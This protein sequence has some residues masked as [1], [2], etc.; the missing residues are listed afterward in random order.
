[1]GDV[2]PR[3]G[4]GHRAA[5]ALATA[6]RTQPTFLDGVVT[7]VVGNLF[8]NFLFV[9]AALHWY[10]S[11]VATPWTR[12]AV[13]SLLCLYAWTVATSTAHLTGAGRSRR[14]TAAA[15][16]LRRVVDYFELKLRV[17]RKAESAF[18][19]GQSYIFAMG[20]HGVHG[21]GLMLL[22]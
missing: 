17:D 4:D 2:V 14:F 1:M 22:K 9:A 5:S 18:K 8:A 21:F 20:P 19:P 13:T 15:F 16:F 7:L 6:Q 3:L 10:C 11:A 12:A